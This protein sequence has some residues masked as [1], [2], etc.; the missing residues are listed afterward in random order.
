MPHHQPSELDQLLD[1]LQEKIRDDR[2]LSETVL[3]EIRINN[4]L[5]RTLVSVLVAIENAPGSLNLHLISG[6]P[7]MDTLA[8]TQ[9]G[10]LTYGV[11][12]VDVSGAADTA[13]NISW[14]ID[15]PAILITPSL[16]GTT[17]LVTNAGPNTPAGSATIAVN[18]ND[19]QGRPYPAMSATFN[20][21]GAALPAA[22][23]SLNLA[24]LSQTP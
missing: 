8:N 19:A 2:K 21:G 3:R 16:D 6:T 15:N 17:C 9:T 10:S 22:P 13:T 24:L 4:H 7:T 23:G 18:G 12:P 11:N 14:T 20:V 1:M 5:V